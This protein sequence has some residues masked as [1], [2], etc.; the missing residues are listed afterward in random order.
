MCVYR[1][2]PI[3]RLLSPERRD[4]HDGTEQQA[5]SWA[6]TLGQLFSSVS[7]ATLKTHGMICSKSQHASWVLTDPWTPSQATSLL[8]PS[9]Q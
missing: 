8:G 7:G 5:S 6:R 2:S 9:E 1:N 3:G 4:P